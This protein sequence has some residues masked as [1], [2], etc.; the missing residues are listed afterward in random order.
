MKKFK[1]Q[2]KTSA[3][4]ENNPEA[5]IDALDKSGFAIFMISESWYEDSRAQKEWRFAKDMKKPMV[6]IIKEDGKSGFRKD[7]FT[8][9]LIGT[10][11]HYGDSADEMKKTWT[12]LQAMMAAY[13]QISDGY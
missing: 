12:Y 13:V 2:I 9:T 1:V 4:F 8:E 6:Y 11:N 3:D 7:M 10:I 5:A